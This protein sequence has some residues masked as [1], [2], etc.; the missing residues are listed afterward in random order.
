NPNYSMP[1]TTPENRALA[2]KE[3]TQEVTYAARNSTRP[4]WHHTPPVMEPK[5]FEGRGSYVSKGEW[6]GPELNRR[7]QVAFAK[8]NSA[9]ANNLTV[10]Q[11]VSKVVSTNVPFAKDDLVT[12]AMLVRAYSVDEIARAAGISKA[13]AD[14]LR[15]AISR[16]VA[17][18]AG[19][20]AKQVGESARAMREAIDL[21][22]AFYTAFSEQPSRIRGL[23]PS[24]IE[25]VGG[26]LKVPDGMVRPLLDWLDDQYKLRLLWQPGSLSRDIGERIRQA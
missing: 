5:I 8:F 11:I 13:S 19:V 7:L 18:S 2:L 10:D 14:R 9:S 25:L 15:R 21:A 3:S 6:D 4:A 22:E 24:K 23:K 26:K 20:T 17:A 12:Q 1:L 16:E